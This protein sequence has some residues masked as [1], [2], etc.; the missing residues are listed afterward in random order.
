[1]LLYKYIL[2]N[3][4]IYTLY[5]RNLNIIQSV[6]ETRPIHKQPP[7][8]LSPRYDAFYASQIL[9]FS[10]AAPLITRSRLSK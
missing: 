2:I 7:A 1:M 10:S 6:G 3:S 5:T 9:A 8:V 4:T